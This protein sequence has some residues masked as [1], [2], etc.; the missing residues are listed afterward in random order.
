MKRF[1]SG[2]EFDYD[3]EESFLCRLLKIGNDQS[4]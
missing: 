3:N 1:G 2:L 4:E